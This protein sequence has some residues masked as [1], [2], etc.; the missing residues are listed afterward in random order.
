LLRE[1][2]DEPTTSTTAL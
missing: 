2:K 1:T